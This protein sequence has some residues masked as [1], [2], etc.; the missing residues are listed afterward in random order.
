MKPRRRREPRAIPVRGNYW[1]LLS[2]LFIGVFLGLLYAWLISPVQYRNITP[3]LL[4]KTDKERYRAMISRAFTLRGDLGRAKARIELLGDDDA[5]EALAMQ[6]QQSIASGGS[7]EDARSLALFASALEGKITLVPEFPDPTAQSATITIVP[8]KTTPPVKPTATL[9]TMDTPEPAPTLIPSPTPGEPYRLKDR[10]QVCD[11]ES[12][13]LLQVFVVDAAGR[14]VP[15]AEIIITWADGENHF[16]TGLKPEIDLGYADFVMDDDVPY[17]LRLVN[18]LEPSTGL[19]T[20]NCKTNGG[21][22]YK[23]GIR[24]VYE[25]P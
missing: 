17:S 4:Q 14:S 1:F 20:P 19:Q 11:L 25:Q 13:N 10:K 23:G 6:A 16:F 22:E 7:E 15:G 18:G 9:Q 3:A 2:G 24:L 5:A 8:E 12:S 21:L